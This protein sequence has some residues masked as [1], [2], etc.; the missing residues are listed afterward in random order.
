MERVM[1]QRV[2]QTLYQVSMAGDFGVPVDRDNHGLME[3]VHPE[4]LN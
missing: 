3:I 4:A 2:Q 1:S